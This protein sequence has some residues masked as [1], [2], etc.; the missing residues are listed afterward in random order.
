MSFRLPSKITSRPL[1]GVVDHLG[2]DGH[3]GRP[4]LLEKGRLRLD[5]RDQRG[6]HV[7][8]FAA[9]SAVGRG[10]LVQT[11]APASGR[12]PWAGFRPAG[13]APPA[14]ECGNGERRRSIDRQTAARA[15]SSLTWCNR[16]HSPPD[17]GDSPD[18]RK[19]PTGCRETLP[20]GCSERP[21]QRSGFRREP[22]LACRGMP[23]RVRWHGTPQRAFPTEIYGA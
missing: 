4:Q 13:R 3:A 8:H 19:L 17:Y 9:K 11:R 6:H 23:G 2:Q 16:V 21:P 5:R 15:V 22:V 20:T 18:R 1:A 7:D 14:R 12:S 10:R